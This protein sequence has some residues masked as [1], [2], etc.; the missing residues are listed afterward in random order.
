MTRGGA[1]GGMEAPKAMPAKKM[2][3]QAGPQGGTNLDFLASAA[4]VIY[5][6]VPDKDGVV[7]IE[8]KRSATASM[9]KSTPKTCTTPPGARS[10]CR[11]CRRN[12][13]TSASRE[14]S[15]P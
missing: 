4:P 8:R 10:R 13:P 3:A 6:L 7:R 14:I 15:I 12:S 1:A 5:N 11:R 2:K 9:C